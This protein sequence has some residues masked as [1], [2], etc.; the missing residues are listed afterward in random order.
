MRTSSLPLLLLALAGCASVSLGATQPVGSAPTS[1]ATEAAPPS[2]I[3]DDYAHALSLARQRNVPIF[4]DAWAPW[5]HTCLSMH[6][7]VFTDRR[8]APLADRFVWLAI[9]TEKPKNADFV[10]RHPQQVW[11]TLTIIDPATETPI[12][13][14]LGSATTEQLVALLADGERAA[15]GGAEGADALLARADR[16][17]A[18]GKEQQ[19]A[20]LLQDAL[21]RAPTD[22]PRRARA[23]ESLLFTLR[24]GDAPDYATCAETAEAEL[25]R[26][27]RSASWANVAG[28]GLSCAL[29]GDLPG[30]TPLEARARE[31]LAPPRIDMAADDL[32]SLYET[33]ASAR[34]AAGDE[35][36]ARALAAEWLD[37]LEAEAAAAPTPEARA[38]YDYHR[39]SASILLGEPER[40]IAPLLQ[41]ERDFPAN[42]EPPSRLA[43]VYRA[44]GRYDEAVAASDR[45]LRLAYGPRKVR[46]LIER[47]D[48][49]LDKGD[50]KSAR[51][52]YDEALGL[53]ERLPEAQRSDR[54]RALAEAGIARSSH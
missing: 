35:A 10:A 3:Q 17:Y 46:L 2:F 33:V 51:A 13:R 26:L 43:A 15:Q 40:A 44:L 4:V 31:A 34:K 49:L 14:W 25:Q 5:C 20:A 39:M 23:V 24:F 52:A 42:Y 9:D 47:G 1:D 54:Y 19:A 18:A 30:K 27:P 28:L 6:A 7:N 8:L 48:I 45:A 38:V 32:S 36:G 11:P 50:D 41:S 53:L 16:L 37:F 29:K 22:W 21:A 12:L